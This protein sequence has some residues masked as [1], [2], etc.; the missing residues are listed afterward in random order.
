MKTFYF[1]K[2]KPSKNIVYAVFSMK[3]RYFLRFW[4]SSQVCTNLEQFLKVQDVK[5]YIFLK[6]L[7]NLKKITCVK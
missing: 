4:K 3:L 5:T 2:L 6:P 1:Q 7:C